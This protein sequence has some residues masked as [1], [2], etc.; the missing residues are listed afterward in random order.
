MSI[1]NIDGEIISAG[2]SGN[3]DAYTIV[4]ENLLDDTRISRPIN[5]GNVQDVIMNS[6]YYINCENHIAIG[7]NRSIKEVTFYDEDKEVVGTGSKLGNNIQLVGIIEGA[8]FCRVKWWARWS[9]YVD[10]PDTTSS[11]TE[12]NRVTLYVSDMEYPRT[13]RRYEV[14]DHVAVDGEKVFDN[15]F[16]YNIPK[17]DD[18]IVRM[19]KC[20]SIRALNESR[21][22]FRIGQ[23][24]TYV[25]RSTGNWEQVGKMLADYG[26]DMCGFEE[27]TFKEYASGTSADC[28]L[29][30]H[31]IYRRPWQFTSGNLNV[32]TGQTGSPFSNRAMVSRFEVVES[33]EIQHNA[34]SGNYNNHSFLYNKVKLPRFLDCTGGDQY[35]GFYVAHP[36]VATSENQTLEWQA[37]ANAIN[38]DDCAFHVLTA[39]TNDWFFDPEDGKMLHWKAFCEATGMKPV[40]DAL[41]KTT[42]EGSPAHDSLD[43]IF[44]SQNINVLGYNII[45]SW[46][47][48]V[49][50]GGNIYPISDHDFLYADLQFDYSDIVTRMRPMTDVALMQML[51]HVTSDTENDYHL[52]CTNISTSSAWKIKL[53][54]ALTV[55]LTAESGYTLSSVVVKVAGADKTSSYYSNGTVSI[56]ADT[57]VAGDIEITATAIVN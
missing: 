49:E 21:H 27:C 51:T 28:N 56:P 6:D 13:D 33:R 39:D 54:N 20:M 10:D 18:E 23:F 53:T 9:T 11:V 7:S 15:L 55:H 1:Y 30:Q 52:A 3:F 48:P 4:S 38:S 36:S 42:T 46:E 19:M 35:L 12:G 41:S 5:N 31:L 32:P 2:E 47:Y 17:H 26:V 34:P 37:I 43:N 44:V 24:N 45:N 40:H 16:K 14:Q 8:V 25:Q 22:A 57:E 29:P 50:S